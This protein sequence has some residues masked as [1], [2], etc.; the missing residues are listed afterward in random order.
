MAIVYFSK[1]H[2]IETDTDIIDFRETAARVNE[3]GVQF[4]DADT[5]IAPDTGDMILSVADTKVFKFY[6]NG[7]YTGYIDS[8]GWHAAP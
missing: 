2:K 1:D 5:Y 6:I 7:V 8:T 4:S 3:P